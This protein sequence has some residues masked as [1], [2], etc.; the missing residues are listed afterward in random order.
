MS[1]AKTL[2]VGMGGT[3]LTVIREIRRLIA[4]RYEQGLK[5]PEV[6][7]VRFLYI[8]TDSGDRQRLNWTV[9][10]KGIHLA[11]GEA[12]IISGDQLRPM[13]ERP[14]DFPD[15]KPWLPRIADYIGE[16]GPG[17]KGIRPYGRLI[18]EYNL[19]KQ[20][21]Q[22]KC[23]D[24]FNS[25]NQSFRQIQDWRF[26]LVAGLSGGTGSG[27]FLPFSYDLIRWNLYQKGT[28][29]QKFRAF[30][31]LPPLQV[32][33]RH[34]RYHPNAYAALRELNYHAFHGVSDGGV[35]IPGLPFDNCYLLEPRNAEGH[36]IGL[37]N[38]P[39]L[40]AQRLFVNIQ[41]GTAASHVDSLMDNPNLGTVE[42]D[43]DPSR[44]HAR[45]VSTF[46]LS[47]V[48]FPREVVAQCLSYHL[49]TRV[50]SAWLAPRQHPSDLNQ[51]VRNELYGL[52]LS[53]SHVMG[54]GDPFGGKDY[55]SYDVHI[56]NLVDEK[57]RGV[58]KGK[59]GES[60]GR[61]RSEIEETFRDLGLRD[62]YR[63]RRDDAAGA[64]REAVGR[65]R[66]KLTAFLRSPRHGVAFALAFL[67]ELSKVLQEFKAE[68]GKLS[69]EAAKKRLDVL[70]NNLADTV[71]AAA[72]KEK[73]VLYLG[74]EFQRNLAGVGDET[75]EYLKGAA[76]IEAGQYAASL[77]EH[78]LP[79][80]GGLQ[81]E[82][83]LW[84]GR[85]RELRDALAGHLHTI[86]ENLEKGTRENGKIIFRADSLDHLVPA[87]A[88]AEAIQAGIE[89][90]V[91]DVLKQKEL[92][93]VA[94]TSVASPERV[95]YEAAYGWVLSGNCPVDVNRLSLYDKF[96]TEY[97]APLDRQRILKEA[98]G[99][100]SPFLKFSPAEVGRRSVPSQE[101]AVTTIPDGTGKIM[102]DGT[103][104]QSAVQ[105]DLVAAGVPSHEIKVSDDQERI[106]FLRE[107]QVF[108]LR[109]VESLGYLRK[110]YDDFPRRNALHIDSRVEPALYDLFMLSAEQRQQIR[111]TED[112]FILARA[113]GWL[114]LRNNQHTRQDE[115]RCEFERP[116]T[117][118]MQKHVLGTDWDGAFHTLVAD[119]TATEADGTPARPA[120]VHLAGRATQLRKEL[121][122]SP[123]RKAELVEACRRYLAERAA[124]YPAETD[125]P[126]YERDQRIINR[127]L[128]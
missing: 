110:T 33:G 28:A 26:Y 89:D 24:G 90:Q 36:N 29:S 78:V 73:K 39:L 87:G 31:I 72:V 66:A 99:L 35:A 84:Q 13:V 56:Q 91:R 16:P 119:V 116:G 12:A 54:D 95:V 112:A 60:A 5:A 18:Y 74:G 77:L 43:E 49:A 111:E 14:E 25:L 52:R 7:A 97:P 4:E 32:A 19:N 101:V 65:L 10:N 21:I 88:N 104:T 76:R 107:M 68:A 2:I 30:F 105:S 69:G 44:R 22:Q 63:Q 109:F 85:A 47:T 71:N 94:L 81:R 86:L 93:L 96:V 80:V 57:F 115:I 117:I 48:S 92:D 41:G 121:A 42:N 53:H 8:D 62:F 27:M 126:R 23:I 55:P 50:A 106:V 59:I 102:A 113:C 51:Q 103:P 40:V 67:E 70:R 127:I 114:T 61:I 125:D 9:L 118:G 34:D 45:Q 123:E 38:L 11:E 82:L 100:S 3:G 1:K 108:P 98:R 120:R 15:I 79:A 58:T 64:A 75:K 128:G 124:E 17:A 6:A 20:L 46:G 37:D 122:A 83:E